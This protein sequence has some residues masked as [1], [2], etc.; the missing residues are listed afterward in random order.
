M[1]GTIAWHGIA[2]TRTPGQHGTGPEELAD[3]GQVSG[4]VLQAPGEPTLYWTGDTILYEPCARR[5]RGSART[6]S[7]PTPPERCGKGMGP[8]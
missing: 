3:M 5:S 7:S 2:V 4:F 6:S 1:A 8:S